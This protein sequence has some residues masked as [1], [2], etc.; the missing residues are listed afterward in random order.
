MA[1]FIR[2]ALRAAA[3][4][5]GLVD[6]TLVDEVEAAGYVEDFVA[7]VAS[8]RPR[9]A[10]LAAPRPAGASPTARW[11]DIGLDGSARTV[12]RPPG[13]RLDSGG[14][15]KGMFGDVL[16]G[17]LRWHQSFVVDAAGDVVL[18]GT[19]GEVRQVDVASPFAERALHSFELAYGA[20]ATSGITRRVWIDR[21]GRPAHHLLDPSTGEPAFTG[22][23]QAT[24]LARSGVEA[25]ALAKA[26]LLSGPDHAR[27]W[28]AHGGL[29]VH[30]DGSHEVIDPR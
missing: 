4:T 27:D 2:S 24:A 6:P 10:A 8:P 26:A 12:R 16:A 3:L 13:V 21:R 11:R 29:I 18:G 22:L 9:S 1:R 15:A 20:V 7:P 28:L 5:R 17:A 19:A 25:E 30:D 23:V 14:V